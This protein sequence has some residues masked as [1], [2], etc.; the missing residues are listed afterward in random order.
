MVENFG[1][2]IAATPCPDE[3][4]IVSFILIPE[5]RKLRELN[6]FIFLPPRHAGECN[7][8]RILGEFIRPTVNFDFFFFFFLR[9]FRQSL[10]A[11]CSKIDIFAV[12]V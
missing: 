1:S 8:P 7:T 10:R 4:A 6:V 12:T 3:D 11:R 9:T 2:M 5:F